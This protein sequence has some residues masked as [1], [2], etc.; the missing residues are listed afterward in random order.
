MFEKGLERRQSRRKSLPKS[1]SG[2]ARREAV[3]ETPES[4]KF[5]PHFTHT[6][7]RLGDH[8]SSGGGLSSRG[9]CQTASAKAR[10][11]LPTSEHY[12][13]QIGFLVPVGAPL[14]ITDRPSPLFRTFVRDPHARHICAGWQPVLAHY[15]GWL[16]LIPLLDL[17]SAPPSTSAG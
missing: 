2:P 7:I 5:G 9:T 6:Y 16:N 10:P 3:P 17:L 12:F 15:H 13:H 4:R 1:L 14:T 11:A 8:S